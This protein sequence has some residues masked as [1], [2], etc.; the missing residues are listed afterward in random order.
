MYLTDKLTF[1]MAEKE[2]KAR[3]KINKLLE[4]AGWRF[5]DSESEPANI[6]L[7][8]NV[9]FN[10]LGEDFEKVKGGFI[11]FLLVDD[12]QK[13][14]VVVEAK[15]EKIEP[16]FAKEQARKYALAQKA[17]YII[18]TNGNV[19]YLW[20]LEKGNPE[21]IH[22]FPT[23]Q[24][25]QAYQSY[26]PDPNKLINE[27]IAKD[28][29]ALTQL[30]NY[31][32]FP[33]FKD[34]GKRDSFMKERKLRFLRPYQIKA[35]ESIQGKVREGK[36]RFLLEM[37]TG[38]GKTLTAAAIAKLFYKT[39]NARR[40]L[41]LVD[42]LELERQ[43][44]KDM[45]T[46]LKNDI[47][48]VVYKENKG[49]WR[50]AEI[51]I[52]TIQSLLVNNKYKKYFSPTD[53]DL[54]IS[55]ESHRLLGGGNSRAL[56]EY[57]LGYKLGLTATPKDYLKNIDTENYDDPRELERRMLLDTY[58]TF[59]C[60][61]GIPTF[62]YTLVDGARDKILVQPT[63]IDART[64]ITT[65]LLSEE[66]YGVVVNSSTEEG[67]EVS[68]E[69]FYKQRQFER[70]FFSDDTNRLFIKT[71]IDNGLLDPLSK[72]FGKS[73]VFAVSQKHAAKL[74]QLLN[75]YADRKWPNKYKSDFAVQVTSI[76]PESQQMTIDFSND[77]LLGFSQWGSDDE[78]LSEYKTSRARVCVTV[79]MMTTGWDCPNILNL[80]LMRPIFSPTEF[81]Q[82]KGRGTRIFDFEFKYKS[83]F[84]QEVIKYPKSTFKLFDFF[85][86]CE[87][88]E[89]KYNYDEVLK[90]PKSFN[91]V[92]GPTIDLPPKPK[93][94]GYEYQDEDFI[95][96]IQERIV[97]SEGMKVDRMFFQQFETSVRQDVE[98]TKAIE[99]GNIDAA[100]GLTLE[101][102]LNKPQEF[103][104]IEKLRKSL[105]ID[106]KVTLREIL[107][108]IFM[109]AQI[110]G[111]EELI[112]DEFEKFISTVE[113]DSLKDIDALRYFFYAYITDSDVRNIIDNQDYTALNYTPSFTTEDFI[114]VDDKMRSFIPSYIKTY[115]PLDKFAKA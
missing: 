89:E 58:V 47:S 78:I 53:F 98:I 103:Y 60:E 72:E 34:D 24:S 1:Q 79:G 115:I 16:L 85:A 108:Q 94:D 37:A 56:F 17:H 36:N 68:E 32:D 31:M 42:R 33:E 49:D 101:K 22:A 102:Y 38:T 26:Q 71:F 62:R 81:I 99:E 100:M 30:P 7:E 82:I 84:G 65:K 29:I 6:I 67:V 8:S 50:R 95:E 80:A 10:D 70:K 57:F 19:H 83:E 75:E 69:V 59:G 48:T 15:S 64:D 97:G 92:D 87:F 5:F 35:I 28:Y 41:F 12:S 111:K 90:L 113:L 23:L 4:E 18:L 93:K 106:R 96:N 86:V 104:T 52:T 46:Y 20:N 27:L 88:F 107:E 105:K 3:I 11:D 45:D 14:L 76:I 13:P 91:S 54:L 44:Q 110:K 63:V 55:D 2:A 40:I 9:K 109:G 77:K 74:T 21:R 51:V 39:G 25:L 73:L 114:R 66:G 61:S 43:A 112:T